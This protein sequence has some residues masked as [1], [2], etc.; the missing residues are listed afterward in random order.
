MRPNAQSPPDRP[1]RV[2]AGA[3]YGRVPRQ[4]ITERR[5]SKITGSAA[6]VYLALCAHADRQWTA[7]PGLAT[8]A[9][10]TG[11]DKSTIARAA[12]SLEEAGLIRRRT[13]GGQQRTTRYAILLN[14][15]A[16][17]TVPGGAN[18]CEAATVAAGQPLRDRRRT[19]ASQAPNSCPTATGTH[20][21][22]H[23]QQ[24]VATTATAAGGLAAADSAAP[25]RADLRVALED[26]GIGEP[27]LSEL[28]ADP[29]LTPSDVR[30]L[31]RAARSRVPP[32]GAGAI[33]NDLRALASRLRRDRARE[34]HHGREVA[35]HQRA[36]HA[37]L[38]ELR[39][40][41]ALDSALAEVVAG[42]PPSTER[43]WGCP[44]DPYA[45]SDLAQRVL[46]AAAHR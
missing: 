39:N 4:I 2:V 32:R 40:A 17:A 8:L 3:G 5:L 12:R 29:N 37:A 27:P 24:Q 18:G 10:A 30:R 14:C 44:P 1:R 34:Q 20:M 13:G 26:A 6:K 31:D 21:N 42:A 16:G 38:D 22:R 36:T 19:V 9:R 11:L 25:G 7:R 23:E 41:G 28:A 46:A 33:V 15:D 45:H 35:A 43:R